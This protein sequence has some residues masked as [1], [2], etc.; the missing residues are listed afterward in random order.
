MQ[1][2]WSL[3]LSTDAHPPS[4]SFLNFVLAHICCTSFHILSFVLLSSEEQTSYSNRVSS[5]PYQLQQLM[6][7]QHEDP[8]HWH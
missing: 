2:Q 6:V 4:L 5:L 1:S 8:R 7:A 3:F